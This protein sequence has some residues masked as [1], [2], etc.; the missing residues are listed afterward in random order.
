MTLTEA[1]RNLLAKALT[2]KQLTFTKAFVGDGILGSRDPA[3][4]TALI[5]QKRELPIQ[6]M[7]TTSTLGTAEVVLE[8]SNKGLSA[9]FF[10]REYG[11]FARDPDTG[12]QVLYAYTNKG[13]ESGYLEGDNG[14]DQINY[15]LSL[16]TV[17]DQAPNVTAYIT[18]TNQYVTVSRLEQK[19]ADLY[20]P[21]TTPAGFWTL[22]PNNDKRI[23]PATLDQT[24]DL[25][26]GGVDVSGFNS[27]LERVEDALAQ[28][29]LQLELLQ[30]FPGYS[31]FIAEDFNDTSMLDM[32]QADVTSIVAGDDSLDVSPMEGMLPG[33]W[34][35]I[36]DGVHSEIVQ[37][38]SI[39]LENG[40]QRVILMEPVKNT[41]LLP[42]TV[43]YRTNAR[44]GQDAA[45]GPAARVI[46]VWTPNFVWN[47]TGASESFN[48]TLNTSLKNSA[49]V[50][51]EGNIIF[52]DDGAASVAF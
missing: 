30:N 51:L 25:I 4:L 45:I 23:R 33:S 18:N 52:T 6:S 15:T 16:V 28:T 37:V 40:V 29:M 9:G 35:T 17:I 19:V 3:K 21:Y 46:Q 49:G 13:N 24:R 2:G 38:E 20:A 34:Y 5:S 32:F 11:L 39:N 14:V 31:H 12:A 42:N 48:V 1:G 10:V 22:A 50:S 8:M 41:Y 47:G 43:I 7:N 44:I 26:L 36:T 27:R